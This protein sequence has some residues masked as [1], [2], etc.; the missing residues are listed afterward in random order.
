M[1]GLFK[2][3]KGANGA[4]MEEARIDAA[5]DSSYSYQ[6]LL[7]IQTSEV[8]KCSQLFSIPYIERNHLFPLYV[9]LLR[10]SITELHSSDHR[11]CDLAILCMYYDN[12][13]Y[14]NNVQ[15]TPTKPVVM[16]KLNGQLDLSLRL[17]PCMTPEC[18]SSTHN[19]C[20]SYL[21]GRR[22]PCFKKVNVTYKNN[23]ER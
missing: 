4:R 22:L 9:V 11:R 16:L 1:N 12:N 19:R 8:N 3:S 10:L 18:E 7:C 20:S 2:N 6:T 13:D 5:S 23:I 17:L 14:L 21:H 15:V